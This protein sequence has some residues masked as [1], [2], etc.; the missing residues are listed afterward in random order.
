MNS[1]NKVNYKLYLV[2]DSNII[3]DRNLVECVRDAIIGGVS[4][5]QLREKNIS[6]R[7]FYQTALALKELTDYYNVP[8]IINDRL[9]I[10]LAV[11]AAGLHIGQ[12]DLPAIEARKLLGK[13]KILGVSV[14]NIE[15]AQKAK[16]QGADYIGVGAI[17][18][19]N[20]KGDAKN[21]NIDILTNIRNSVDIPIVAIGGIN[22]NNI[23]LLNNT[24]INGVAVISAILGNEDIIKASNNLYYKCKFL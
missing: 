22:E 18:P 19:T 15:Q 20:S 21:L 8:L 24:K 23:E 3:G 17:F 6:T 9:D 16:I 4:V 7:D 12:S 10:A 1:I 13:D 11:D 14:S 2:T 5:V